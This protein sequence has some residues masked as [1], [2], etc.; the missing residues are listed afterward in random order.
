[1]A[2][3]ILGI[4]LLLCTSCASPI[5]TP[6]GF[7]SIQPG[8]PFSLVKEQF[9]SPYEEETLPNGFKQYTYIQRITIS[10]N[11]VDQVNYVI[12]VSKGKVL[13][14]SRRDESNAVQLNVR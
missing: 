5:M 14:T 2:K 3:I 4:L 12:F 6:E 11:V 8:M 7:E 13:C 1:M 9:G 10:P